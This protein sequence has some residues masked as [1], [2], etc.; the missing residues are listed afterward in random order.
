MLKFQA[1]RTG[2]S[3]PNV[4]FVV[5]SVI[6]AFFHICNGIVSVGLGGLTKLNIFLDALHPLSG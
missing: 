1:G 2:I 5:S 6:G 3:R 4:G